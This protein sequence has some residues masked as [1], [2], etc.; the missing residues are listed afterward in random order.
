M[1]ATIHGITVEGTPAEIAEVI[2][3]SGEV[4]EATERTYEV[5]RYVPTYPQPYTPWWG[6]YPPNRLDCGG[7]TTTSTDN[8]FPWN[9]GSE[10]TTLP[11]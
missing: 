6:I 5:I 2:K 8:T 7:T 10:W 3:L 11:N 9:G 4:K 1:K